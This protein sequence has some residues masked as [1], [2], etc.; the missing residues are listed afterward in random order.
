MNTL[1]AVIPQILAQGLMALREMA[2]LPAMVNSDYGD[3]A[4]QKGDTIDVPIPSAVTAVP[5]TPA[6]IPPATAAQTPSSVPIALDQW[7]EAPFY[8]TDKD[9]REAMNG[10]IPMQASEAIRSLV[11]VIH[12]NIASHYTGIYGF[13]GVA[14]TT[15]F[16]SDTSEA[17]EARKILT[18]Q[19]CPLDTRRV[20]MDAD[21]EANALGLRAFQDQNFGVSAE[22]IRNGNLPRKLG[23]DWAVSQLVPSHTTAAAGTVLVD[24]SGAVAAGSKTI[25]M[26]GL[27]TKPEAGDIFTIAGD[28]QTYVVTSSTTLVGTD[29][30]VSF[31]P[32]LQVAIGTGDNNEEVTFK[33]SHVVN[34]AF[35]RDAFAFA[36][37]PLEDDNMEGL[38]SIIQSASDPVSGLTL[39]LEVRR[40]HKRIRWS[41]DSLW[42]AALVR[43]PLA[44]RIA[45]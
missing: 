1:T 22:D 30:D 19:L 31:E 14:A 3:D 29:S 5:V 23:F 25:H 8:L 15:P 41:F 26:D 13:A 40:E 11:N 6:E 34:L 43:A 32:G 35:H 24:D 33:A 38:G 37:R 10:F 17:T 36:S 7:Y 16:A 18:N 44:C 12:N 42:G 9:M 2:I 45:G 27:T 20:L 4:R 21:A 39:R 28:S